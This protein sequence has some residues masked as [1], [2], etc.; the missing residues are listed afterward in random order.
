YPNLSRPHGSRPIG[1]RRPDRRP[2]TPR[3]RPARFRTASGGG[4]ERQGRR[5]E[6]LH[7]GRTRPGTGAVG[8][9]HRRP[10]RGFQRAHR[11]PTPARTTR[12]ARRDHPDPRV[13]RRGAPRTSCRQR[14]EGYAARRGRE[15]G[16][17][18]VCGECRGRARHRVRDPGAGAGTIPSWRRRV[19]K[20]RLEATMKFL[21][22]ECDRQMQFEERQLPG[23]GTLAA[24]FRCPGC[25]RVVALLTNPMETQL[26][27]SL[28]VKIGGTTIDS[29]PLETVR[30]MVTTG[31]D[32]AFEDG[33]G[34]TGKGKGPLPAWSR[35]AQERLARAP[36]FVRGM[37]KRIYLD[38]AKDRG[39]AEITPAVMD[40]ARSELGL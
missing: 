14:R 22:V 34:E 24:A 9:E 26:V 21:C 17:G 40:T 29:Q 6:E 30:G 3:R 16:G 2:T 5:R 39:I 12:R 33:K 1:A 10:R 32:D 28:G 38:Y 11:S 37:V 18:P 7:D 20:R 19:G 13:V 8:A 15:H 4:A 23:D 35:E 25:G 27:A 36:G 31:R